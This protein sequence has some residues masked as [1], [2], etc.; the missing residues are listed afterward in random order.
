[1]MYQLAGEEFGDLIRREFTVDVMTAE[2]SGTLA[3]V[4]DCKSKSFRN[5]DFDLLKFSA[6]FQEDVRVNDLQDTT[7]VSMHFQLSGKSNASISGLSRDQPMQG[8]QFNIINCV[9]PV[10]SFVFPRQQSY[11]Y[12]CV[13]L[14]TSFFSRV[15]EDCGPTYQEILNQVEK[16]QGFS[17]FNRG[18][19]INGWQMSVL[20]LLQNPPVADTLK[21]SYVQGKVKELILLSLNGYRG[22]DCGHTTVWNNRDIEKLTAARDYL[23]IN[24]LS[25]LTLEGISRSFL[26]NEFKLKKGFKE[27]FGITVFGYIH[28]LRMEHAARLLQNGGL[29]IGEISTITGY[30]SD[31]SFIRAFRSFYGQSP[32]KFMLR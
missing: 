12:L 27:L 3:K 20:Q 22:D 23:R 31:S 18:T 13:G 32:G 7:H 29:T 21:D 10:S 19:T 1:M 24:Y 17:L 9:D 26:L 28:Q 5:T 8:G 30:T 2:S 6:T 16:G 4:F 11:E 15:V 14:K 25:I